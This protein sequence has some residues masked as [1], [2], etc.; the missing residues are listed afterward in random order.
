MN[1]KWISIFVFEN[2]NFTRWCYALIPTLLEL[3]ESNSNWRSSKSTKIEFMTLSF[4]I[5]INIIHESFLSLTHP[6][7]QKWSMLRATI[8][9]SRYMV[10]NFKTYTDDRLLI[11]LLIYIYSL[12][13][14]LYLS[15]VLNNIQHLMEKILVCMKDDTELFKL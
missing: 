15:F 6:L 8:W 1:E 13:L 12:P 7:I 4:P 3:F 2:L 9:V 5:F 11:K 10:S 14:S